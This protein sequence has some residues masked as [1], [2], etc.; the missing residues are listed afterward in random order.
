MDDAPRI[1]IWIRALWQLTD[2]RQITRTVKR[3]LVSDPEDGERRAVALYEFLAELRELG[4]DFA[5]GH[6]V[7]LEELGML[8]D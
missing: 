7:L 1:R 2:G 3:E 6:G 4:H 8:T 5:E